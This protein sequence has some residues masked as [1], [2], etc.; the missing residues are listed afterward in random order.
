[1]E[2]YFVNTNF[3]GVPAD[4]TSKSSQK[5]DDIVI[6]SLPRK[7]SIEGRLSLASHGIP[8]PSKSYPT[9]RDT[10]TLGQQQIVHLLL[11]TA[12]VRWASTMGTATGKG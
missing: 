8:W 12:N 9:R 4:L 5:K 10:A 3:W 6:T 11:G 7:L 2:N 1:M